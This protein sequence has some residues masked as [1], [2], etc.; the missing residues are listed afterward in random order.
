[1]FYTIDLKK[2]K[3]FSHDLIW[4]IYVNHTSKTCTKDHEFA[5]YAQ[6]YTIVEFSC[7]HAAIMFWGLQQVT[8]S[9]SFINLRCFFIY[10]MAITENG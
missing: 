6:I 2:I 9:F 3:L 8:Y 5:K 1:M 7:N 4:Q 10:K